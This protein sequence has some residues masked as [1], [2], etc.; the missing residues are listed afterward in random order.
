MVKQSFMKSITAKTFA[1]VFTLSILFSG[2]LIGQ[3]NH[4]EIVSFMQKKGWSVSA[5]NNFKQAATGSQTN[6]QYYNFDTGN[7]YA[8]VAFSKSKRAKGIDVEAQL[9]N[10]TGYKRNYNR[11]LLPKLFDLQ[12]DCAIFIF[13]PEENI[14]LGIKANIEA[15]TAFDSSQ[16]Y[17]IICYR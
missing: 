15:A 9:E 14:R 10:G 12:Y 5:D 4:A 11:K 1:L 13:S 16:C 6:L 7:K 8:I 3:A 2:R 17:Y